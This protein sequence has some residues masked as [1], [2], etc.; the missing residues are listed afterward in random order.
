MYE[1]HRP[2]WPIAKYFTQ[3]RRIGLTFSI[4]FPN[5]LGMRGPD[6][7]TEL[8]EQGRPLLAF[9]QQHRRPELNRCGKSIT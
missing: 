3:P 5:W 4:T 7:L 1:K 9:R 6:D 2:E 8:G